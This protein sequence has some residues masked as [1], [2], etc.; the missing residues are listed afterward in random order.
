MAKTVSSSD[1]A[2]CTAE[3][4]LDF[5]DWNTVAQLLTDK[6]QGGTI[7]LKTRT[8]VLASTVLERLLKARSGMVEAAALKGERYTTA[9]LEALQD[10]DT[11]GGELL[12]RIIADLTM[13]DLYN[14]RPDR[15]AE[16]PESC[17]MAH[18]F[19]DLLA[20]GQMI[21]GFE[22]T[23]E[24]GH[25][26]QQET[27]DAEIRTRNGMVNQARRYFGKRADRDNGL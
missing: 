11:N 19:L 9:D 12:A 26:D 16:M 3:Q 22:E 7:T 27:T 24:A 2:F 5:F 15:R 1:A 17:K 14:R 4:F 13:F 8:E 21:F 20:D 18:Q 23:A 10:D 25:M 6:A